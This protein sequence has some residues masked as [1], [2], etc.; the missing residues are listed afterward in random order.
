M[1]NIK[2]IKKSD[3]TKK[4]LKSFYDLFIPINNEI[5]LNLLTFPLV[6]LLSLVC[7]CVII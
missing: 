4:W 6:L 2:L 1:R 7:S 5:N 3:T